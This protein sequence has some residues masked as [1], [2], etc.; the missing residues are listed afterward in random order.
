EICPDG[1]EGF[2]QLLRDTRAALP[3][4]KT[5]SVATPMWLPWPF[6]RWG[7]S[8]DYLRRICVDCDQI[9]VMCYDSGFWFPRSYV[10]LVKQQVI[11]ATRAPSIMNPSC[12]VLLG[13]P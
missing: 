8:D 7:W 13:L 4:G 2:A 9:V 1:D 5:L 3:P 6:S 11:H 12:R 10:G